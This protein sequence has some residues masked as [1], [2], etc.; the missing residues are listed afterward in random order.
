MATS[1]SWQLSESYPSR[2]FIWDRS[3]SMCQITETKEDRLKRKKKGYAQ[4]ALSCPT[5]PNGS[6]S[7]D[8]SCRQQVNTSQHPREPAAFTLEVTTPVW[9]GSLCGA[10]RT[11]GDTV[12]HWV[13]SLGVTAGASFC[14]LQQVHNI[15]F[16]LP[17]PTLALL[18]LGNSYFTVPKN[19]HS[20][21]PVISVVSCQG[22]R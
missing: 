17:S 9:K 1:S 2:D 22:P 19:D 7:W 10:G 3:L 21:H 8:F 6:K 15:L 12:R 4:P 16:L 5:P 14:P 20:C 11:Q 18:T 13:C